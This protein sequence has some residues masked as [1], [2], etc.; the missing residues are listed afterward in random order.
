[1]AFYQI[2]E[3]SESSY[4]VVASDMLHMGHATHGQW[5]LGKFFLPE[6]EEDDAIAI[7]SLWKNS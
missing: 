6:K 5:H 2:F 3:T 1:M 7:D 4:L